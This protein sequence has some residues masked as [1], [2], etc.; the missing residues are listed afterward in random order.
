MLN[1][2]DRQKIVSRVQNLVLRHHVNIENIDLKEW[3][4][5]VHKGTPSLLAAESDSVFEQGIHALLSKLKSSHTDF[6]RSDRDPISPE[7]AIGATLR[8]IRVRDSQ[9][10]MFLDVFEESPA[11]R[12]GVRPGY[13]LISVNDVPTAPPEYPGFRFGEEHHLAI[14]APSDTRT[15]NIVVRVPERRAGRATLPFIEPKSISYRMLTKGAGIVKIAYF[16]GMFGIRFSRDLDTAIASLKSQ[17]CDRLIID[18][19]SCL[20]GSLGF[21]RLASYMSAD[22]VPIGYDITRDS[23]R[24]GYDVA[25]LPRVKMPDTRTGILVRLAQFSVRD[26]SLVLLTQGLGKQPFH[27]RI[28]ILMNEKTS[29]AG[30]I[31]VQF[32]KDAKLATL[33]GEKT[34]GLVLGADVFNVGYGYK[35]FLP[36]FAWYGP[37]G[38]HNEGSGVVPD[39]LIDVDPA[40]LSGGEDDQLNKALEIVQ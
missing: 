21:A 37:S 23:Q 7:H 12:S 11:A 6:Y 32:A 34:A 10:W 29:S 1:S 19:R 33:V 14:Q 36:V 35:L 38:S 20:G 3:S 15:Q 17:G 9:R 5:E 30:E 4:E 16:S 28:V 26:K 25:K 13:L 22:R 24:R 8:S 31:V 40:R 2:A 18:L 27:G 39:I